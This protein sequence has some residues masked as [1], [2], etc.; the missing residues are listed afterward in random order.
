[1]IWVNESLYFIANQ[2]F[3]KFEMLYIVYEK[4]NNFI[5]YYLEDKFFD[6]T[7]LY[8]KINIKIK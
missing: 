1:M 4:Q 7:E 5:K 6:E 3:L 2:K 8:E